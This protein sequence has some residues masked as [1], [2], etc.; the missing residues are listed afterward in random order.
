MT[1]ILLA[2][3]GDS[4]AIPTLEFAAYLAALNHSRLTALILEAEPAEHAASGA[5][6]QQAAKHGQHAPVAAATISKQE[7]ALQRACADRGIAVRIRYGGNSPLAAVIKESRFADV[8]VLDAST[9]FRSNYEGTPT[10]FVK[11]VLKDAE[12]PVVIAPEVFEPIQEVV[13]TYDGSASSVFAMKQFTY[14]FPELDEMKVTVLH[15]DEDRHWD[16][17][18]KKELGSWLQ[19]HY[20]AIGF[21]SKTGDTTYELLASL[22]LRRN[23]FI[24][25][26]AYGRSAVSRFFRHSEADLLLK[27]ISRPVFI[28]HH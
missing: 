18:E 1:N 23:V 21:D 20:S 4:F 25:M 5:S 19:N 2:V 16:D 26:G 6:A 22:F 10:D 9:S 7:D 11:D 3:K 14:L 13:F 12:C 17:E 28:A 27:T 15:I 8:V 24:V